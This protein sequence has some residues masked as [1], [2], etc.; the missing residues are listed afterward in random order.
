VLIEEKA[1][2]TYVDFKVDACIQKEALFEMKQQVSEMTSK[3]DFVKYQ[4]GIET[5]VEGLKRRIQE[6]RE[7]YIPRTEML[8]EFK[9]FIVK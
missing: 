6:I 8:E 3:T 5:Q 7:E 9:K 4:F 1:T 2:K